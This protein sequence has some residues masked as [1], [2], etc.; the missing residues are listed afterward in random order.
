MYLLMYTVNYLVKLLILDT[1]YK[2]FHCNTER[3]ANRSRIRPI[4]ESMGNEKHRFKKEDSG[5]GSSTGAVCYYL[6]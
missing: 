1:W 3:V 6:Q 2:K 5:E 4:E